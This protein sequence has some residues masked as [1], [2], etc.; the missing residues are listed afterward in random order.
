MVQET[1]SGV[2]PGV[3]SDNLQSIQQQLDD[4]TTV[5]GSMAARMEGMEDSFAALQAI[6][7][8]RLPPRTA[9]QNNG[10][11]PMADQ[12][13]Q[14][15]DIIPNQQPEVQNQPPAKQIDEN[16]VPIGAEARNAMPGRPPLYEMFPNLNQQRHPIPVGDPIEPGFERPMGGP[17]L[18]PG[19]RNGF[20]RQPPPYWAPIEQQVQRANGTSMDAKG[21]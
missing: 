1:R 8:E 13:V 15:L 3:L 5:I 7:E 16:R 21:W 19:Q 6:L 18:H 14:V 2:P 12:E 17:I 10:V 11:N 20:P 9:I 4:H